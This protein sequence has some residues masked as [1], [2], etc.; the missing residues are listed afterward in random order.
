MKDDDRNDEAGGGPVATD[1]VD[2]AYGE[3][4]PPEAPARRRLAARRLLRAEVY[5]AAALLAFAALTLFVYRNPQIDWD[6]RAATALQGVPGLFEFM[7]L[8]SVPGDGWIPHAMTAVTVIIFLL[9]RRFSEAGALTLS[10]S[11]GAILSRS[12]KIM[13]ARPRPTPELVQV[14]R[15]IDTMSFPSGHVTFYVCYFGFLFFVAYAILPRGSKRRRLALALTALPVLLVGPSRVYLGEHWPSD[16]LGAY[17]MSGVWV[18][19]CLDFYRRW[20]KPKEVKA[21]NRE[22]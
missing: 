18:A 19:L 20:K 17:L 9:L 3:T 10:A 5:Y 7:R 21:V 15:P 2:V 8:A 14:F 4:L 13:I 12:F 1:A 22:S 6:V 16:T 11:G